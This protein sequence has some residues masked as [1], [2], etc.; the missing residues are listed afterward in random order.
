MRVCIEPGCPT[1]VERGR[2]ESC[3]ALSVRSRRKQSDARRP[4][5]RGRGYDRRW[6]RTR[7]AYLREHPICEDEAGCIE[8]ATEVDHLDDLGPLGPRG[9]DWDNLRARCKPCHS[10][11]TARDRPA[12]W[13]QR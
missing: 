3:E 8:P 9:H 1:L 5:A 2:C 13:A 7:A 10:R 6:E 12:G 4:S 11:R